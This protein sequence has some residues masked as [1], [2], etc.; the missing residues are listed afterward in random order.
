M[1]FLLLGLL[2]MPFIVL[3]TL[4]GDVTWFVLFVGEA[5]VLALY[6]VVKKFSKYNESATYAKNVNSDDVDD[7]GLFKHHFSSGIRFVPSIVGDDD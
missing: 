4:G 3:A 2:L 5:A 7:E 6:F 1:L